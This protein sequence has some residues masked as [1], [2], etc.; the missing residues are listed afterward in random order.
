MKILAER[1]PG[2]LPWKDLGVA[3]AVEST[4]FFTDREGAKGGF[5]DHI[6]A[7]A[8][9]VI[10]SAPAKGPDRT[11]VLGVNDDQLKPDEPLH[12]QRQLHRPTAWR[13]WPC[14]WTRTSASSRA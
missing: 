11:V 6:K 10:I 4:G 1:E 8:G 2:K 7:G 9:R 13:P 14:C 12:L 5:L 3:V